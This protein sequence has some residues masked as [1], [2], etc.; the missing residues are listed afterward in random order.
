LHRED[1]AWKIAVIRGRG[2][3]ANRGDSLSQ[4]VGNA[5]PFLDSVEA[6]R[7]LFRSM[8]NISAEAPTPD[9]S[10]IIPMQL[11]SLVLDGFIIEATTANDIPSPVLTSN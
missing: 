10:G 11:G 9:Y 8:P 7:D 5:E 6:V 1:R 3:N 2:F 4:Q